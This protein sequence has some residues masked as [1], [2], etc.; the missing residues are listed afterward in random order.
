MRNVLRRFFA[1]NNSHRIAQYYNLSNDLLVAN[2]L[3]TILHALR[4]LLLLLNSRI[5]SN[6]IK[7]WEKLVERQTKITYSRQL[8]VRILRDSM[9]QCQIILATRKANAAAD[10]LTEKFKIFKKEKQMKETHFNLK[11]LL[12]F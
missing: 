7:P 2:R 11:F 3:L 4:R 6:K 1:L 8:R 5:S 9:R 10:Y 12:N